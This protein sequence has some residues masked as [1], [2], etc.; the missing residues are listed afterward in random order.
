MF[1]NP[2]DFLN[3]LFGLDG[4][5]RADPGEGDAFRD[6]REPGAD[7]DP[8]VP[9]VDFSGWRTDELLDGGL[10]LV[11][12]ELFK[13]VPEMPELDYLAQLP[14]T[15]RAKGA[16]MDMFWKNDDFFRR[17]VRSRRKREDRFRRS[18]HGV[19]D[20]RRNK[21]E[22]KR[23]ERQTRGRRGRRQTVTPRGNM[24]RPG[25]NAAGCI[26][27]RPPL[28]GCPQT[29]QNRCRTRQRYPCFF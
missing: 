11:L 22:G 27:P 13:Y 2:D 8:F 5:G 16:D 21:P 7:A 9:P 26:R 12:P 19:S 24:R 1:W 4:N 3:G 20:P 23:G 14:G 28:R 15:G 29:K 25:H 10:D 6:V 18:R 17:D